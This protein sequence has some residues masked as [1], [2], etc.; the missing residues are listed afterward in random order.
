LAVDA[1]F[2]FTHRATHARALWCQSERV[3]LGSRTFL[4]WAM[5]EADIDIP[6]LVAQAT[7]APQ[8]TDELRKAVRAELSALW[9]E[10]LT[11]LPQKSTP[12]WPPLP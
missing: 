4:D 3:W 7:D 10:Q 12:R 1:R 5:C 11:A 6:W 8:T 9:A 2:Q